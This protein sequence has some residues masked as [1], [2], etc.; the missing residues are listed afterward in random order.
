ML[1]ACILLPQIVTLQA[2][3]TS[4]FTP[5]S[6]TTTPRPTKSVTL[7]L[8]S[9][10][11]TNRRQRRN[12]NAHQ[13]SSLIARASSDSPGD[14]ADA[15]STDTANAHLV[16]PGGG[17]YFYWQAGAVTYLRS[18]GY[19]V[20]RMSKTGASAGALTATLAAC[21]VDYAFATERALA[22]SE[23]ANIWDRKEGLQ[24]IWGPIIEEWLDQ[25]LPDDAVENLLDSNNAA[26]GKLTLLVS[27]VSDLWNAG[28]ERVD[29]FADKRDLIRCN[30][31]SVHLPWFLDGKLTS[32][33]RNKMYIDGSF[34]ASER[35][36]SSGDPCTTTK[37][38]VLD[39]NRDPAYASAN[40]FDFVTAFS[41]DTIW[42]IL[43][44]GKRYAKY[45]EERGELEGLPIASKAKPLKS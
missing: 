43:E 7:T 17:I 38:L 32:E 30:M 10:L 42:N 23:E 22:L 2:A 16:F 12:G 4:A 28:K 13:E 39:Y 44:D 14:T 1:V 36:Y 24:G 15:A 41:P 45:L 20:S 11:T 25:I 9:L 3:V 33:F 34:L 29:S 27:P 35:D 37:T 19:D 8:A 5:L 6:T 26:T 31:A 40:L 21:G 18:A